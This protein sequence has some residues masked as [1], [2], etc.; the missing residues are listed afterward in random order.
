MFRRLILVLVFVVTLSGCGRGAPGSLPG[1]YFVA[2]PEGIDHAGP[3]EAAAGWY[4]IEFTNQTN[5]EMRLDF[6]RLPPGKTD[7]D[8]LY[9]IDTDRDQPAWFYD[10]TFAPGPSVLP[11]QTGLTVV[12]LT[13]G[14]W[15]VV[16][17]A[18]G[19][20]FLH[21][22]NV[23]PSANG[24]GPDDKGAID[25]RFGIGTVSVSAPVA[26]SRQLWR[27][28]SEDEPP[29]RPCVVKPRAN[30]TIEHLL[31]WADS[32]ARFP[33]GE[34]PPFAI[35]A[36]TGRVSTGQPAFAWFDLPPGRYVMS[37]GEQGKLFDGAFAEFSVSD[38]TGN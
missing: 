2:G 29:N 12:Q 22:L 24:M 5:E 34:G 6:V 17:E 10:I 23:Q 20:R 26:V 1:L 19:D 18:A 13:A 9:V 8:Y 30:V 27:I 7:V 32:G 11:F 3:S 35:V 25:A 28:V 31:A 21:R 33:E 38:H 14:H 16:W 37:D 15:I 4:T 36:S